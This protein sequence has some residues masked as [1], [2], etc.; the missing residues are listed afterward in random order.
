MSG[1]NAKLRGE[2]VSVSLPRHMPA[3]RESHL[4]VE[5]VEE[6]DERDDS[7]GGVWRLVDGVL[8]RADCLWRVKNRSMPAANMRKRVRR[9]VRSTANDAAASQ[10]KFQIARIPLMRS[11]R[12]SH[13]QIDEQSI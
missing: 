2:G 1:V 11:W 3:Y 13:E 8:R 4:L 5:S 9:P 10:N 7:V 6:E 12:V